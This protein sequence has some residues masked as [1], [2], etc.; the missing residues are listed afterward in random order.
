MKE[1]LFKFSGSLWAYAN[2]NLGSV[3]IGATAA[4][5]YTKGSR[6]AELKEM[7]YQLT[8]TRK[9]NHVLRR[10]LQQQQT[11]VEELTI[12]WL[13][14]QAQHNTDQGK[15]LRC[16]NQ[17]K[18]LKYAQDNTSFCL[19]RPRYVEDETTKESSLTSNQIHSK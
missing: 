19:F 15:L 3:L 7:R 13:H 11:R 18:F 14:T 10:E 16:E 6:E 12:A 17:Y 9:D 2:S 4:Y 8:E 1:K 5:M